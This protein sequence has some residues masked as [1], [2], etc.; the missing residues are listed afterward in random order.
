MKSYPMVCIKLVG[1]VLGVEEDDYNKFIITVVVNPVSRSSR[2]RGNI[3]LVQVPNLLMTILDP[4]SSTL[5][6]IEK[7][8]LLLSGGRFVGFR[9]SRQR[10]S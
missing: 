5:A 7:L 1:V 6:G 8:L 2:D 3:T 4:R 9:A 10:H